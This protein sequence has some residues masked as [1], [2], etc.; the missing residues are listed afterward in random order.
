MRELK[1]TDP[2][3]TRTV[4]PVKSY[5]HEKASGLCY[6][7][8]S[9]NLVP[10]VAEWRETPDGFI[11]DRCGYWLSVGKTVGPGLRYLVD[12]D[13]L[14]LRAAYLIISD[15]ASQAHLG[16]LNPDVTGFIV[17]GSPS[18]VRF[19]GAFGP[20]YDLEY[21]A[22]KGGFHQNLI[23]AQRP[24]LPAGF[25]AGRTRLYLYT[26]MNLEEYLAASG[27]KVL[28]DG[29]E[30]NASV[31][32]LMSPPSTGGCISF[33]RPA[34][35][36]GEGPD[37]VHAFSVSEVRDSSPRG[38]P[39]EQTLGEKRLLKDPSS[40]SAYFVESLPFSYLGDADGSYPV[41]WDPPVEKTGPIGSDT[42]VCG[43]TYW[44]TGDVI[45]S[46]VL[47]IQRGAIVKLNPV[48]AIYVTTGGT[49]K[50][51]TEGPESEYVVFT[52]AHDDDYG[53][54]TGAP[55]GDYTSALYILTGSNGSADG[56]KIQYCKTRFGVCPI[57]CLQSLANPIEHNVILGEGVMYYGI[58]VQF[59]ANVHCKNNLIRDSN[60]HGIYYYEAGDANTTI[61]NNTVYDSSVGINVQYSTCQRVTDNLLTECSVRGISVSNS[62][63]TLAGYNGYWHCPE[64]VP[65][66]WPPPIGD[67]N[68]LLTAGPYA[69]YREFFLD[70]YCALIN[71]GSRSASAAGL[72]NHTTSAGANVRQGGGWGWTDAD[73][74][75]IGYHY[76]HLSLKPYVQNIG[77][78]RATIMFH[79]TSTGTG[80][81][82]WGAQP[83]YSSVSFDTTPVQL[84]N[85][86]I[87]IYEVTLTGLTANTLY[88]YRVRHGSNYSQDNTFYTTMTTGSNF[89]FLAYGDNRGGSSAV[90]Q[91]DHF[92]VVNRMLTHTW[93]LERPA[94]PPEPADPPRPRFVLH[95][96]DFVN[97]GGA[98]E[99]WHPHFFDPASGLLGSL[100]LWP[101]IGNHEYSDDS[102]VTNY[103]KL[104]AVPTGHPDLPERFYSFADAGCYFI[105]VDTNIDFDPVDPQE[106]PP[107]YDSRQ[108]D[109]LKAQLRSAGAVSALWVVVLLHCPPYTDSPVHRYGSDSDKTDVYYV[110]RWLAP[111]F[112]DAKYPADLVISGHNHFYE[113]SQANR[114]GWTYWVHYIVTGGAVR[115]E[116]LHTPGYDNPKRV[117]YPAYPGKAIKARH[118]CTID[119]SGTSATLNV[120]L[121]NGTKFEDAVVLHRGQW[122]VE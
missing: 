15:G 71:G 5:I 33:H 35:A 92:R 90:F 21:V 107:D 117:N 91:G 36:A 16:V 51:G 81:V 24:V 80:Y 73:E 67:N 84:G 46:G 7:D 70:Q 86:N 38:V 85:L 41:T 72:N 44:V 40:G 26:E 74:V 98:E 87:Y 6:R 55:D 94:A 79:T 68:K 101:S 52:K 100:P 69:G 106:Q 23:I 20:G 61:T 88:Y 11:V 97:A 115:D 83:G 34:G 54:P 116:D 111:L 95:A 2:D 47:T 25:D 77:S 48:T 22:E 18:T 57:N 39:P 102:G 27:L 62:T 119:I 118:F 108:Y 75:D 29:E 114:P 30:I 49:V 14:L 4:D 60:W 110:R 10:S 53:E 1:T 64:N 63:V 37:M 104:F 3:G 66:V 113:R 9:G 50:A 89:R 82:D 65:G 28:V 42:W 121:E 17:P 58:M 120:V 109:W 12:G 59:G 122:W 43:V 78:D 96:A 112:E 31:P 76:P 8:Q 13:E 103:K 93:T 32:D 56:S 105:V 99:Q 45:V 19:P